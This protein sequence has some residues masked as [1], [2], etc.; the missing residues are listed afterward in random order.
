MQSL[1]PRPSEKEVKDKTL[2]KRWNPIDPIE[3][4][5]D[6]LEEIWTQ[7]LEVSPAHT[8]QQLINR[9]LDNIKHTGLYMQ[10]ILECKEFDETDHT[11]SNVGTI[12]L[13]SAR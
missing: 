9:M 5:F 13:K 12:L 7:V 10:E 8:A 11:W 1:P 4:I 6:N 3:E 2:R